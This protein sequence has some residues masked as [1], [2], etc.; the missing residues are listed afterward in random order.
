MRSVAAVVVLAVA[1]RT[2]PKHAPAPAGPDAAP[3]RVDH[4]AY[5]KHLVDLMVKG[6]FAAVTERFDPRMKASLSPDHLQ[7]GW[8]AM[9]VETGPFQAVKSARREQRG[10]VDVAIVTAAFEREDLDVQVSFG[11]DDL[12]GGLYFK[13]AE[14]TRFEPPPYA[15]P[16]SF[17][18]EPISVG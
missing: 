12:V 1:C 3:A 4:V 9:L 11:Q 18:E 6:D 14:T 17:H 15:P 13:P 2:A 16:G 8:D 7:K 5:A 10:D